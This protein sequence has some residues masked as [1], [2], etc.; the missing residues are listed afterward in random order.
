MNIAGNSF[1]DNATIHQGNVYHY[2]SEGAN[3]RCL[4]DL[5]STDPR[6]DK[7][8]IEQTKGGLL[9]ELYSWILENDKFKL[10]YDD[11]KTQ[12]QLLWITGDPGKGK[13]MLACG[14]IDEL[15]NQTRMNN[16][17]SKITLSYF[18]CQGTDSRIN[19]SVAVLRG[20]LYLIIHQQ[21]SLISHVRN[22]YD[23]AGKSLFEDVNAWT[24]LS[25]IFINTL[26][27]TSIDSTILVID[28]LD[29]CEADQAK[30]LDFI[31][32]HSS[33]P[34]VKWIITSRNGPII[35]HK[36]STHS[37]RNLL[38]LELKDNEASI[39][40]AVDTYIKYSV[41]RL[42]LVQDDKVLQDDLEN[43]MRQKVNGTFLWV[44][45]VMKELEQVES[46]D[47]LQVIDEIPS[48]LKEVYAR[49]LKQILQLKRG[50]HMH[51]IQLLST[52][53]TA[54]R[55][56]SL[57]ELGFLSDLPR[58]ISEKLGALRR[59]VAMCGSFL[60]IRD[61]NVYLVHQ[62]AKD[63]LSTEALQIIF[64]S[65]LEKVHYF[66]YSRSLQGLSQILRRDLW[67]LNAPG[68]LIEE[69]M[70][71]EPDPLAT[72]R[73]S[74]VY[75]ADHLCDGIP[76]SWAQISDL[77][78]NG[79]IHQ[80]LN[81][82]Y[83]YWLEALSLQRISYGVTALNKLEALLQ[84]ME[85]KRLMQSAEI[86]RDARR[87]VLTHRKMIEI[88]PLQLYASALLFGP[89]ESLIRRLF[90]KEE[91]KWIVLKP[92]MDAK[93]GPCVQT[94]EGHEDTII[95]VVCSADGQRLATASRDKS[96]KIWNY[97]TGRCLL[98]LK[99]HHKT[100]GLVAF[101]ADCQKVISSSSDGT[102]KIW[103]A[104]VGNC[105]QTLRC[106]SYKWPWATLSPDGKLAATISETDDLIIW[107]L[108]GASSHII[109]VPIHGFLIA[110]VFSADNKQ[111]ALVYSNEV[112][113][114]DIA[115]NTRFR[116]LRDSF[117][118]VD[119]TAA[120]S[121][122]GQQLASYVY[123]KEIKIWNII[124]EECIR[125]LPGS[126]DAVAV[127]FSPDG[128]RIASALGNKTIKIWDTTTG[129]CLQT[130]H[131]LNHMHFSV[132]FSTNG[133]ELASASSEGVARIWN[134]DTGHTSLVPDAPIREIDQVIFS[135][136]GGLI[137]SLSYGEINIWDTLDGTC[138]Q[139]LPT[140]GRMFAED[141]Q[142]L[143][144][145]GEDHT[146]YITSADLTRY[147]EI[148][149][150]YAEQ[151]REIAFTPD[152][153][154]F[155]TMGD[156]MVEIW[157]PTTGECLQVIHD[158]WPVLLMSCSPDSQ[159]IAIG[160]ATTS[161]SHSPQLVKIWDLKTRKCVQILDTPNCSLVFFSPDGKLL[162]T[163]IKS[164]RHPSTIKQMRIWDVSKGVCLQT[165]REVEGNVKL[166]AFSLDNQLLVSYSRGMMDGTTGSNRTL[167][168]IKIWDAVSGACFVTLDV[169]PPINSLSFDPFSNS[170]IHT[171]L[172]VMDLSFDSSETQN[173]ISWRE[174]VH[175]GYGISLDGM[176]IVNGKERLL[177]LPP[178]YRN[179]ATTVRGTQIAIGVVTRESNHLCLMRFI[180]E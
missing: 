8:R 35:E 145:V 25:Q 2:S 130:I 61:E 50:N 173:T 111:F 52:A 158:T 57:S 65:G 163:V 19:T 135:K 37:S 31:L 54:Y 68:V 159:R 53:C 132:A 115:T 133:R 174:L 93:W 39:S 49:M 139:I 76:E 82:N 107:D 28:A 112:D 91:P 59:L 172:G 148:P 170:R 81:K 118:A 153:R 15:A 131:G 43:A 150:G 78:D 29:E 129:I 22:K 106:Q 137:E 73:Y 102:V 85:K 114:W 127:V 171:N 108:V 167:N 138:S 44:S 157:E 155:I 134:L 87:F 45:L 166:C 154:Y 12:G 11:D 3:D 96:V 175:Y 21:R 136:D 176:W 92:T 128:L 30:L 88:A 23:I 56:L 79:I 26:Q 72:T 169:G 156:E 41:S 58:G 120:F 60:T 63:Y 16:P 10:W 101:S 18:F 123:E 27:D 122:N 75:W 34:R 55:P 51:C 62:S 147:I 40:N 69:V 140:E 149:K 66:L 125:R 74:C 46:W 32:Q 9:R 103:D 116:T 141:G 67:S 90:I 13:T 119:N 164:Y 64:P 104:R 162:G 47:A 146:I 144:F 71:P 161:W 124:T 126:K 89:T 6:D 177:L 100:V 95:S 117:V 151:L 110:A 178:D 36:I 42:D 84:K 99:G 113:I 17:Q 180:N 4:A 142:R 105:L 70:A 165:F 121:P 160:V 33:L 5:R 86:I 80:F 24:A 7:I 179:K 168:M 109:N 143:A 77:E 38:S 97:L 1:G 94:L 20:L 48:D 152:G 98:T 83:L 14:I